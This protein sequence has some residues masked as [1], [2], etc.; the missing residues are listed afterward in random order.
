MVRERRRGQ[1]GPQKAP[2]KIAV[3]LRI[4]PDIVAAYKAKGKGWQAM[5]NACENTRPGEVTSRRGV[6]QAARIGLSQT[7]NEFFSKATEAWPPAKQQLTIRLH[8]N[9]FKSNKG[10]LTRINRVNSSGIVTRE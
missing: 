8:A 10:Y 6:L 5:M 7:R 3:K 9:V 4:D 2:T 1:R